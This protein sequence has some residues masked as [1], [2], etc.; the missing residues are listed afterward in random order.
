MKT[1][2]RINRKSLPH[3]TIE[4][5]HKSA[6]G[7]QS[8]AKCKRDIR[9]IAATTLVRARETGNTDIAEAF[10]RYAKAVCLAHFKESIRD[11]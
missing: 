5:A 4:I 9:A 6:Q 10:M 11:D 1:Y 7:A 3:P 2:Y 8:F